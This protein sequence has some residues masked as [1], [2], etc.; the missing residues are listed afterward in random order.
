V[1]NVQERREFSNT[2]IQRIFVSDISNTQKEGCS[3]LMMFQKPKPEAIKKIKEPP[4]HWCRVQP[5]YESPLTSC[6]RFLVLDFSN[7]EKG[8]L[9]MLLFS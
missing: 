9:L 3:N 4:P 5:N 8:C 2:Q 1:N 6:R 7:T